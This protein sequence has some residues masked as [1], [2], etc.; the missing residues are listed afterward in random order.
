MI[1]WRVQLLHLVD[2]VLEAADRMGGPVAAVGHSWGG[3]A[4]SGAAEAEPGAFDRLVYLSAFVP[5]N[6]DSATSLVARNPK[7]AA[8]GAWSNNFL[9]GELAPRPE[10]AAYAF[11]N[12]CSE[13]EQV[14]AIARL[15]PE[16]VR[17][18]LQKVTLTSE[19]FGSVPKTYIR[20][21]Q[22]HAISVA[23]QD[24]MI[25]DYAFEHV[26]SLDTDHSP[27]LG[28]PELCADALERA[29]CAEAGGRTP[30]HSHTNQARE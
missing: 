7:P 22:D 28:A 14:W 16:P 11:Y 15:Y 30:H 21:L 8:K 12:T 20:C 9:R 25:E 4:I 13:E 27:F 10:A 29:C 19:R 18:M 17:P 24:Q 5:R 6:G 3:F 23:A 2:S 1:G 26:I